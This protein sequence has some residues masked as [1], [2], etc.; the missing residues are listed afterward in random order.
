[1]VPLWTRERPSPFWSLKTYSSHEKYAPPP[2]SVKHNHGSS[3][4]VIKATVH[5][6]QETE[7]KSIEYKIWM[8]ETWMKSRHIDLIHWKVHTQRKQNK[9]T[10]RH[11]CW[12]IRVRRRISPPEPFEK[13]E[14]PRRWKC[15]SQLLH[16]HIHWHNVSV[17]VSRIHSKNLVSENLHNKKETEKPYLTRKINIIYTPANWPL[18]YST[19]PLHFSF[20]FFFFRFMLFF[21]YYFYFFCPSFEQI[22]LMKNAEKHVS[23]K[24]NNNNKKINKNNFS[25]EK[26]TNKIHGMFGMALCFF[27]INPHFTFESRLLLMEMMMMMV[28]DATTAVPQHIKK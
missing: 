13:L 22:H 4:Q 12:K 7:C 19:D 21:L 27:H 23:Q 10:W 25:F 24:H 18:D 17:S 11:L 9:A 2:I 3:S 20:F 26:D 15:N 1:M 6:Q 14:N 16:T 5:H 8:N 28:G